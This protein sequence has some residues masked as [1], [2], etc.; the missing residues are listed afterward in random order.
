MKQFFSQS[1][2]KQ[3]L[4]AMLVGVLPIVFLT[5]WY[6]QSISYHQQETLSIYDENQQLI[7][8]YNY[9]KSDVSGIE[10][11][12]KNN[13]L[14]ESDQLQESIDQKWQNTQKRIEILKIKLQSSDFVA[15]WQQTIK[16]DVESA[17]EFA[18]LVTQLKQFDDLF[19]RTLD[20]RLAKKNAQFKDLQTEFLIGLIIL[21]PVLVI[22]SS[23][24]IFR[25][26]RQLDQVETVVSEVGR[27]QL[28]TP[29]QLSGSHELKQLGRRLDWLRLE[30]K[31]VQQQKE[32]FLRHVTHELK[33][34]LASINE[35]S[36]LLNSRLLG[37]VTEKQSRILTIVQQSV[38]KLARMIDDLLN[39]S[40]ASHPDGLQQL[41]QLSTLEE[42]INRHLS[43]TIERSNVS[44]YWHITANCK[45]P[46]LPCK[47]ILTQLVSNAL[48]HASSSVNVY[49]KQNNNT[50]ELNVTDDGAGIQHDEA[51]LLFQPF[52]QSEHSQNN[53]GSG[54]G[55]AIVSECV[56]Q[57]KGDVKWLENTAGASILITFPRQL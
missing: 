20:N 41:T 44:L 5:L 57:L 40:A 52:Y 18:N 25:I 35:G 1:L 56:K 28:D 46:Y 53:Q 9:I 14:L 42:E 47:L 19:D 13:Q 22:I 4:V 6:A 2:Q 27:G 39:Y 8:D 7:L 48:I 49:I 38:E 54:L 10:K 26:C 34:P 33:T 29:V 17:E 11:A 3:A 50:I 45:V 32:T 15:K 31:R 21:L 23:F 36:S 12:L 51:H 30:L 55:L 24:L 37:D 43:D 16:I